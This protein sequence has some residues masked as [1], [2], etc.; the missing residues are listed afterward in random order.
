[1]VFK[2]VED[3]PNI[4]TASLNA[5]KVDDEMRDLINI[6]RTALKNQ[7]GLNE[8]LKQVLRNHLSLFGVSHKSIRL[9]IARAFKKKDYPL[10]ADAVSLTREQVEKLFAVALLLDNPHRW[11]KQHLRAA[12]KNRLKEFHLDNEEKHTIKRFQEQLQTNWPRAL[13]QM[14]NPV[15]AQGRGSKIIVSTFAERVLKYDLDRPEG[16]KPSWFKRKSSVRSYQKKYFDFPTP[17]IALRKIRKRPVHRFLYRWHK[18]YEYLCEYSHVGA[19]K[20][21]LLLGGEFK[22]FWTG[23]KLPMVARK[24]AERTIAMS[25]IATASACLLVTSIL[26]N[27]FGEQSRVKLFWAMLNDFSLLARALWQ[28]NPVRLQ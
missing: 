7:P 3:I 20:M 28:L 8:E 18:E 6:V 23:Q 4:E 21:I 11:V 10:I 22:D 17:G 27:R 19:G 26:S 15:K 16:P 5:R 13:D 12:W 2:P 25:Y 1:M 24:L 9:I 14:K